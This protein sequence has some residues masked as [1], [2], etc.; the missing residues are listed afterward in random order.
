MRAD[1]KIVVISGASSGIGFAAAKQLSSMGH[2]VYAGAR[3]SEDIARLSAMECTQ[4]IR[5]DIT[6]PEDIWSL[7]DEIGSSIGRIDVLINNAGVP[8]WGAIMDREMDYFKRIM[9][10]NLFGHVQMVK[11]FYPLLRRS[12]SSPV[13]INI[14]S[15]AGNYA[16]PFW[17]P[18]HMSKW[19]LEAFSECLRRELLGPGIRVVVIQ[20]GAI[21]SAAFSSQRDAF[22]AYK[23]NTQSAF[24]SRAIYML[25]RAFEQ[26]SER[27]KK[28]QVVLDLSLIHI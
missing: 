3:R 21:Q 17:A 20:P 4:G 23:A 19:E 11:A 8:G 15:Q 27:A 6:R 2:L 16:F 10:V 12:I 28:P 7:V 22:S 14:S 24:H 1:R 18:Y 25:Q 5:L 13:I 9:D 26:P